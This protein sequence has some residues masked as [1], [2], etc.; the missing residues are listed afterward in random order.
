MWTDA[1]KLALVVFMITRCKEYVLVIRGELL[2][3]FKVVFVKGVADIASEE[4]IGSLDFEEK[5]CRKDI[6]DEFIHFSVDIGRILEA[7]SI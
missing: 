4:K 2:K 3:E 5:G 1:F 6:R 7:C